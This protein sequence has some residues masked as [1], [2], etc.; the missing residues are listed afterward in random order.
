MTNRGADC[1]RTR[2]VEMGEVGV[3]IFAAEWL[4][5]DPLTSWI[6][7]LPRLCSLLA[8]VYSNKGDGK[9]DDDKNDDDKNSDSFKI[10]NND[11][12]QNNDLPDSYPTNS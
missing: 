10:N 9:N 5:N 6:S 3:A 12:V 7:M 11:V 8:C 2:V 4:K 1:L